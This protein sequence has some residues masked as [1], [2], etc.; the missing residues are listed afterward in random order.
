MTRIYANTEI[1]LTGTFKNSAGTLTDP[2]TVTFEYRHECESAW[3]SV[4]AVQQS[5]G[6]YDATVTPKYAGLLFI[7]WKGTGTVP[8]TKEDTLLIEA[9]RDASNPTTDYCG[10]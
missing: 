10:C 3:T 9:T 2:T 6:V 4:T 8:V 1:T 7:R 5:T